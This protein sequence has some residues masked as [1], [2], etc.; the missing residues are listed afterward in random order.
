MSLGP[1]MCM[2]LTKL[3]RVHDN[4]SYDEEMR[5]IMA[6][7]SC[8][9]NFKPSLFFFFFFSVI[10]EIQHVKLNKISQWNINEK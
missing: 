2:A 6:T 10:M 3:Y 7:F 9:I 5:N 8:S 1:M 4:L